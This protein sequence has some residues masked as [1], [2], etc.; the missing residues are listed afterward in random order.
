MTHNTKLTCIALATALFA[1]PAFAE[2]K[3]GYID[4]QKAIQETAAG[5][6]AKKELEDEF[7]KKKKDLEK[8]RSRHQKNA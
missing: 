2:I 6:K 7:N 8:K 3:I 1:A 5:K 4:M